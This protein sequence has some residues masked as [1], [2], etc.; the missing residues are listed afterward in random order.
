MHVNLSITY[1][2]TKLNTEMFFITELYSNST[3]FRAIYF[4]LK[5]LEF[6]GIGVM[7]A[8]R[9][10]ICKHVKY[11]LVEPNMGKRVS[12]FVIKLLNLQ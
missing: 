5:T 9:A 11:F 1:Q 4:G 3:N 2:T 8:S 10:L 12:F 7:T 6:I